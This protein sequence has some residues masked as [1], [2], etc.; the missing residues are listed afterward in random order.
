M[1]QTRQDPGGNRHPTAMTG[2]GRHLRWLALVPL[3]PAGPL[4]FFGI[5]WTAAVQLT[6]GI[7]LVFTAMALWRVFA[8]EWPIR[9]AQR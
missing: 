6:I 2:P 3:V 8:G 1:N 7:A 9:W 4:L 5:V